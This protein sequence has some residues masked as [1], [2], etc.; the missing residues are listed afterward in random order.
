[1]WYDRVA[2]EERGSSEREGRGEERSDVCRAL[3]RTVVE[4]ES[5][6]TVRVKV[7]NRK[8]AVWIPGEY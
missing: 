4:R 5:G 3:S 8:I 6:G 7:Q 2:E 1:M